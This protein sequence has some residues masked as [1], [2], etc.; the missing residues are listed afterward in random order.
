MQLRIISTIVLVFSA[1][2]AF[3]QAD[4]EVRKSVNNRTPSPGEPV[5]FLIEAHNIGD[6][7]DPSVV[8]IDRLPPELEIPAGTAPAPS[9]GSFDAATGEWTLGLRAGEMASLTI[10]AIVTSP[11]PPACI[12]NTAFQ[13][14][15]DGLEE[16]NDEA[17]AAI[18]QE[19][20]ERCVDL[21]TRYF[22]SSDN[23][24]YSSCNAYSRF[25][26]WID[27]TNNGPDIARDVKVILT[28]TIEDNPNVRF[29]DELCQEGPGWVCTVENIAAGETA[30]LGITSDSYQSYEWSD[31]LIDITVKSSD[32]DY[33]P[34][35][36]DRV[37][38]GSISDFSNCDSPGIDVDIP[39]VG[40]TPGCFIAT[41][42]YGTPMDE[43]IDV[44][45]DFRDTHLVTNPAGRALVDFYYQHSPPIAAF[46]A[47]RDWLRAIVRAA[48]LPVVFSVEHPA[49]AGTFC[50]LGAAGLI[51]L[52]RRR[53]RSA[54][55]SGA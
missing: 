27:I 1:L 44:L 23:V 34:S 33:D 15:E 18:Y 26:G 40:F 4:I 32:V 54:L 49:T 35:N 5:E 48:L 47:K 16:A 2:P 11:V 25:W 45:R 52:R 22:I 36:N 12:V 51:A 17:R 10:P 19:G 42:A 20:V 38:D 9:T 24:T 8:I 30:Y 43:R 6:V 29:D 37:F 41:A 31:A 50:L 21:R 39:A 55:L 53:G 3:A 28:V 7:E 13:F 46:I 14:R